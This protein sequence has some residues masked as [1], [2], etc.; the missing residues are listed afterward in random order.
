MDV[1]VVALRQADAVADGQYE[2][3]AVLL[4]ED[5]WDTVVDPD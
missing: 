3:D 1:E 2:M 5:V 4:V